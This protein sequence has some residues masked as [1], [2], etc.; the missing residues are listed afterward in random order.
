M[1]SDL[2]AAVMQW[3][4]AGW[5]LDA[6]TDTQAVISTGSET[7]HTVHAVLSLVTLGLW[8]IVWAVIAMAGSG[9]RRRTLTAQPDGTVLVAEPTVRAPALAPSLVRKN[10]QPAAGSTPLGA[11]AWAAIAAGAVMVVG[12]LAYVAIAT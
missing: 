9:V 8:L 3:V 10:A 12:V 1:T 11:A 7:N 4:A 2:D 6:R 5:R